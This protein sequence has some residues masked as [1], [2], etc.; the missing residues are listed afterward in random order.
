M[1]YEAILMGVR[2]RLREAEELV[3]QNEFVTARQKANEAISLAR[4]QNHTPSLAAAYYALASIVWNSGG[5]SEEA[6][7]FASIAAQNTKANT[8]TDLLV[9]T[10]IARIK[11]V[12][13][14]FE[15]AILLSEDA[16]KYYYETDNVRGQ[17]DILR[18]LGDIYR[19]QGN[20]EMAGERYGAALRVYESLEPDPINHAGVLLSYGALKF[21]ENDREKAKDYWLQARAIAEGNGF[22]H[23]IQKVDEAMELLE[24]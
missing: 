12:R 20:F 6:H 14:N 3:L 22:R 23:I 21:Q 8:Q 4:D 18:S 24:E 17:A 19:A 13:G 10:L 7:N 1:E 9:R 11:A 16:L 15:A 5:T 2:N